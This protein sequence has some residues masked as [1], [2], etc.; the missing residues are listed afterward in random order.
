MLTNR[1]ILIADD[2]N[3]LTSVLSEYLTTEHFYVTTAHDG[4]EA[5]SHL[6][7]NRFNIVVLDLKMPK[8]GGLE[9][10][11]FI[12]SD[13]A[14]TKTIVLTAYADLKSV[15]ECKK[16]GADD[17]IEKPY[18]IGDLLGAIEFVLKK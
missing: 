8:L 12:K 3:E 14:N 6:R 13:C 15:T 2:D 5:V 4:E 10:L 18:D 17:V 1:N 9:V 11:K 7:Q 16:L